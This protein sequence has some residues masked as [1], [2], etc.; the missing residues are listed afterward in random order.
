MQPNPESLPDSAPESAP[1]P[2]PAPRKRKINR[3]LPWWVALP[4]L[5]LV[6]AAFAGGLYYL[7]LPKN[8]VH[9]EDIDNDVRQAITIGSS[10]E[11]DARAWAVARGFPIIGDLADTG[12]NKNGVMAKMP[13]ESW[14]KE[15]EIVVLFRYD[16]SKKI[17]TIAVFQARSSEAPP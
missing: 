7:Y 13:N 3:S 8:G 9:A 6:L 14:L 16:R 2:G 11:D 10:T 12:G 1:A 15:T 5:L 4:V 17:T